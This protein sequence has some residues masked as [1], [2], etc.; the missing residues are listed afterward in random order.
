VHSVFHVNLGFGAPISSTG[1]TLFSQPQASQPSGGLFGNSSAFGA[2]KPLFGAPTTTATNNLFG[3]LS[4][5]GAGTSLFGA[6]QN[7]VNTFVCMISAVLRHSGGIDLLCGCTSASLLLVSSA[8]VSFN[9]LVPCLLVI[10]L[11][12]F[13]IPYYFNNNNNFSPRDSTDGIQN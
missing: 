8:G 2:S 4:T 11:T 3:G 5:A 7:K 9:W 12:T 1:S 10:G 6:N 13:N